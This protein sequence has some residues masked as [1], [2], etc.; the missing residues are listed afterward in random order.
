MTL[1]SRLWSTPYEAQAFS[2]LQHYEETSMFLRSNLTECGSTI[3]E[4]FYS[5]NF[6]CLL[7][8]GQV[9][10]VFCLNRNGNVM[11]QTNRKADY[12]SAILHACLEENI[13][14]TGCVADWTLAEPFWQTYLQSF[15]DV[16]TTHHSKEILFSLPLQS[17]P[18]TTTDSRIR[19]LE[20]ADFE[21]W[22]ALNT[23]Y[24]DE[25]R[26]PQQG[27]REERWIVFQNKTSKQHWWGMFEDNRLIAIAAY[28]ACID[29]IA[30]I[31]GVYTLPS[32]RRKGYATTLLKQILLDSQ[33]H[34]GLHKLI[35]FTGPENIA[36]QGLYQRL[37]FQQTGNF[38]LIFGKNP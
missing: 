13:P 9:V 20:A 24:F 21:A 18:L 4:T 35:L 26:F 36:A 1:Q 14:I 6:K 16:V 22:L 3:G 15:P 10:A 19:F 11:L 29:G 30:Q 34:H 2:L 23:A 8:G 37:G 25:L 5:G 28:N 32:V 38:G 27:T 17:S 7:D 33:Q 31:G 12:S